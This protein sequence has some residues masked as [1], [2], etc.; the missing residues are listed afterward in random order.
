MEDS[1]KAIIEFSVFLIHRLSERWH[2]SPAETYRI[3]DETGAISSYVIP[4]YDVLH[5]LGED[6]LV[7]DLTEY[8]R[9]RG[10]DL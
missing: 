1:A 6:Y 8:V 2:R 4:F 7:D 5:S 3:L 10:A 9:R